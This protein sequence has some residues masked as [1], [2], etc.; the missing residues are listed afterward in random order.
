MALPLSPK[1]HAVPQFDFSAL[2]KAKMSRPVSPNSNSDKAARSSFSSVRENDDGLAQTFTR[3]KIS[4]YTQ[5]TEE[6]FDELSSPSV[7]I[8]Q[9]SFQAPLTQPHSRLHGFWFPGD[10][11]R[12]WKQTHQGQIRQPQ[13][14]GSSQTIL[15]MELSSTSRCHQEG[16][17]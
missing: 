13:L 15:D 8:P 7:Q 16:V 12:G 5:G 4:S 1:H 17:P 2:L 9:P 6:V 14:R 3:S 11:F 10:N